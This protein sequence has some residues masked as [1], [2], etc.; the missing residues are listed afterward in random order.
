M[1]EEK[2]KVFIPRWAADISLVTVAAI[3]GFTFVTVK[4][5]LVEMPPHTFNMTRFILASLIMLMVFPRRVLKLSKEGWRAGFFM[6][7]ALLGGY[8]FQTVG[9]FYTTASNSGFITGLAVVF[10]PIIITL[11]T[12]KPPERAVL[13]GVVCAVAGLVLLTIGETFTF[14]IGDFLTLFCAI[15]FALHIVIVGRYCRFVDAIGANFVQFLT[16]AGGSAILTFF[17]EPLPPSPLTY[18]TGM[19]QA[20]FITALL[21]TILANFIVFTMQRFTTATRTAIVLTSEPVFAA[22]FAV[23]FLGEVLGVRTFFGGALILL[24]MLSASLVPILIQKRKTSV[25]ESR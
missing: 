3:W 5:A 25:P 16:V 23:I 1:S 17:F 6:G 10:V 11:M 21:A 14:N 19:W 8:T 12:R 9:L 2:K 24:G 18:S 20:L 13:W 7:L 22:F 15:S 4:D